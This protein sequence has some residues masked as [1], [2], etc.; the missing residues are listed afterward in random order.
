MVSTIVTPVS[1]RSER[2]CSHRFA[3][4]CGSR[5]GG[6]LVEE[7]QRRRVHQAERDVEAA[8]LAAGELEQRAT[9]E[10]AEVE[11]RRDDSASRALARRPCDRPC[12]RAWVTS[13]SPT[14][15]AGTGRG[16][17]LGDVA[18]AAAHLAR[19]A[20]PGRARRRSRCPALGISSVV[21]M[22]SVVVLPAPFGPSR[23]TISPGRRRG[24]CRGRRRPGRSSS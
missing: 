21:S 11:P 20:R 1:S 5:P 23:P 17:D 12:R 4:L 24:R 19:L 3:R 14:S 15:G 10:A 16:A 18:D 9:L 7:H 22:R 13:S 2:M 6:R 8:A